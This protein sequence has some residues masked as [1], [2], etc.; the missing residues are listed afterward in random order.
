MAVEDWE[1]SPAEIAIAKDALTM[2][3]SDFLERLTGESLS[4]DDPDKN[5]KLINEFWD[6][7]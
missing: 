1:C 3:Y 7:G 5:P 4:L 6:A 2:F